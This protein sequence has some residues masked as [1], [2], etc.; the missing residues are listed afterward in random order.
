MYK[1][2]RISENKIDLQTDIRDTQTIRISLSKYLDASGA[3]AA[4][5]AAG[6]GWALD[7][8][9][10]RPHP[11]LPRPAAPAAAVHRQARAHHQVA[12]NALQHSQANIKI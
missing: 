8:L 5:G 4:G 10:L 2:Y 7:P 3:G 9:V 12:S 11:A 6:G 1:V